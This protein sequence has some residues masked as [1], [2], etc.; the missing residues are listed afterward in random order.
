MFNVCTPEAVNPWEH[1]LCFSG[2]EGEIPHT[3][4]LV[5]AVRCT[6]GSPLPWGWAGSSLWVTSYVR[7][8]PNRNLCLSAGK[9]PQGEAGGTASHQGH[10]QSPE[11][12]GR[13]VNP[14]QLLLVSLAAGFGFLHQDPML[15]WCQEGQGEKYPCEVSFVWHFIQKTGQQHRDFATLIM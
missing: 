5:P 10:P 7:W 13:R 2:L 14:V 9:S 15:C 4:C 8:V 11:R 6:W 12:Q 1:L 3:P